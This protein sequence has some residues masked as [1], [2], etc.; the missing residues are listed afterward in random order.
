MGEENMARPRVRGRS[1]CLPHQG[2][3]VPVA[4]VQRECH[5]V[6]VVLGGWVAGSQRPQVVMD[7]KSRALYRVLS[8][9][10][11]RRCHS[12]EH[13]FRREA[14][15]VVRGGVWVVVCG[16]RVCAPGRGEPEEQVSLVILVAAAPGEVDVTVGIVHRRV[17]GAVN[18]HVEVLRGE[19]AECGGVL[20]SDVGEVVVHMLGGVVRRAVHG[21]VPHLVG[22]LVDVAGGP[23]RPAHMGIPRPVV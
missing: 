6:H 1:T 13:I 18:R 16:I 22:G 9:R 19:C 23:P 4:R 10:R 15:P 7:V 8:T 20:L 21:V 2:H 14:A 12:H 17:E 5:L 3:V 11:A